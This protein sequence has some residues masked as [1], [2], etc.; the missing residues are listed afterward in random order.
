MFHLCSIVLGVEFYIALEKLAKFF[1]G[2][3]FWHTLY[4]LYSLMIFYYTSLSICIY[5]MRLKI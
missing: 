3:L 2:Y 5:C 1:R 4:F